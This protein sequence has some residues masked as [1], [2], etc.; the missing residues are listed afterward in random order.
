MADVWM[1]TTIYVNFIMSVSTVKTVFIDPSL[2]CIAVTVKYGEGVFSLR[3]VNGGPTHTGCVP[4][5]AHVV[6]LSRF[7]GKF[8]YCHNVHAC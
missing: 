4:I 2:M 1:Q 7:G 5:L 6:S 8:T 3:T